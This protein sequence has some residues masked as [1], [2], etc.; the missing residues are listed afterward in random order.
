[1]MARWFARGTK[2]PPTKVLEA[3]VR[4]GGKYR[5]EVHGDKLYKGFGEYREVRPP[6]R[7]VF[8]WNW[9]HHRFPVDTI[10]TVEFRALGGSNFTEVTLTHDLLPTQKDRD[11][12]SRGWQECFQMLEKALAESK[13]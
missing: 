13:K 1:M 10:V 6:E 12:H 2:H 8:T 9:E 3:D 11:D 5:I 4:P 7:L